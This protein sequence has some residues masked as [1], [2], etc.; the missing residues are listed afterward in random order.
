RGYIVATPSRHRSGGRYTWLNWGDA[1]ESLPAYLLP[2][3]NKTK[4]GRPRQDDPLRRRYSLQEVRHLLTFVPADSR[5]DWRN[6]GVILG[7]EFDRS[8]KAWELYNEWAAKWDGLKGRGHDETMRECFY[9]ISQ[10]TAERELSMGTIVKAAL[11]NGWVPK[12]GN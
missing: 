6:F 10:E 12:S 5:D 11:D 4:R 8:D 2:Q 7:R 9:E 3:N 1:L